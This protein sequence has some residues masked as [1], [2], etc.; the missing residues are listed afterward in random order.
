[1]VTSFKGFLEMQEC[2]YRKF[3]DTT[4]IERDGLSPKIPKQQGGYLI[5]FRHPNKITDSL[6]EFSYRASKVV[7]AIT[8]DRDNAHKT[9]SDFLVQDDFSPDTNTLEKLAEVVHANK[10][11]SKE[12]VFD[13][14][15]WALNQNT[16]IA[17]GIPTPPV[18]DTLKSIIDYAHQ[19]D[20]Q[21]RL[22]WGSH[23]TVSRFLEE[24]TPEEVR[25]LLNV[26]NTEKPLGK[27]RPESV[28]VG[29]FVF[30]PDGFV[31]DVH[32]RFNL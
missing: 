3:R 19:R 29:H 1:M 28:D 26:F 7:P 4:A 25:E 14:D 15:G 13:Y 21:L 30:T 16:G 6:G 5:A 10:P 11:L 23:I 2:V 32:E 17:T 31:F 8:Y 24:G 12:I 22:P 9:I 27:S 18:Y 20:I